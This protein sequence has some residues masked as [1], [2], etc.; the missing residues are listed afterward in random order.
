[1]TLS[2]LLVTRTTKAMNFILVT[3]LCF[4]A[5]AWSVD[6]LD[7]GCHRSTSVVLNWGLRQ[8]DDEEALSL[9]AKVLYRHETRFHNC[10]PY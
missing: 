2:R 1:M 7:S 4:R 3:I 6:Y 5:G 8:R 9:G 10:L